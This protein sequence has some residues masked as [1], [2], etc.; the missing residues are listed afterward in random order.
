LT[1]TLRVEGKSTAFGG[2]LSSEREI[3]RAIVVR[4]DIEEAD[5]LNGSC[6]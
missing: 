3:M 4:P 2:S 1:I 5:V 6:L